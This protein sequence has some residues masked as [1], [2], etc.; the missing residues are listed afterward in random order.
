MKVTSTGTS[1][2][3]FF[4]PWFAYDPNTMSYAVASLLAVLLGASPSFPPPSSSPSLFLFDSSAYR[5]KPP[6]L[7]AG[8]VRKLAM[9]T[10]TK[11]WHTRHGHRG[12]ELS[13]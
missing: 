11:H 13:R 5:N 7:E 2:S 4:R 3:I 9:Q 10:T 1:S 12:S 6:S 8:G